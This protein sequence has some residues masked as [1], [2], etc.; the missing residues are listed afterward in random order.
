LILALD[1]STAACTAALFADEGTLLA[2]A[3][4][5]IGRGHAERLVPMIAELLAGRE[6]THILVGCGPGSF[7]GLRVGLAAAHGMAIGWGAQ[8]AGFSSMALLALSAG[9]SAPVAAAMPG[10]HG[11]LFVQEF[12]GQPLAPTTALLNLPP[13]AAGVAITAE[14]V[15]GPAAR[16]LV[17]ARGRGDAVDALPSAS[18][19]L[20]L[21]PPLR[22]LPA[23]PIYARA[24]DARP[25][26]A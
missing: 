15:V 10:G 5:V 13:P 7:T 25:K 6:P 12:A 21:P 11:E 3:D 17:E 24:P 18:Q 1:T 16:A 20:R 22:S 8:L 2:S 14:R 4:E 19:V 26:A 9:G 23:E